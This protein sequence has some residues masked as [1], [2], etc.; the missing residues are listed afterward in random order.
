M[1]TSR[2]AK[3]FFLALLI[4]GMVIAAFG[5]GVGATWLLLHNRTATAEESAEFGVFWESWHL[6]EDRFFGELPSMQR[7]TWGAI[8]GALGT[9][10]DPHTTFLEP[11]PRQREKEDLSGRFGG[12][13]AYISLA[14]DGGIVLDPMPD[15]PAEQAGVVEGDVVLKVDD[16]EITSE[17]G[18]DDVVTLVRGEVGTLVRLTLRR[19]GQDEPLVV[20]ITRQEIPS[21]SVEWRMLE[22]AEGVGY[23]R[24]TIFSGRTAAELE[25]A[26]RELE[27]QGMTHLVLDLRGNGGGLLDAAVDV[28]SQFLGDGLVAFQVEKDGKENSFSVKRGGEYTAGPLALL[29]DGGSA[30]ASE[31]VAGA[32]QDR[33]RAVLIGQKTFGKGSVQSVHDLSDGSSVHITYAKWLTPNRRQIDGNGLQPNLQVPITDADRNSGNDPQLK[34]AIEYLIAGQ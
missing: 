7:V 14:E 11:Q 4:T 8:R 12:I 34:R 26:L 32:L 28:A 10:D 2:T 33:E 21:P 27:E 5:A 22:E 9:L 13:G 15:L 16:T 30:S 3:V 17:M 23:I 24:L 18:V 31:I 25:D 20:E 6:V 29:V 1:L 19:Q